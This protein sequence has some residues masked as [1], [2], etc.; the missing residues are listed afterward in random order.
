MS[1]RWGAACAGNCLGFDGNHDFERL[2][3]FGK[4]NGTYGVH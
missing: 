2:E 1:S 3:M 4:N